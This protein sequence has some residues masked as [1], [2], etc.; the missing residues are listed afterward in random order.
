MYLKAYN[1][2]KIGHWMSQPIRL[3]IIKPQGVVIKE[4]NLGLDKRNSGS[5]PKFHSLPMP[6]HKAPYSLQSLFDLLVG[7]G[8]A[9]AD[10]IA[11]CAK[12]IAGNNGD[13]LF[14]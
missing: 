5:N 2:F 14:L 11:I 10:E 1:R 3:R 6:S 8:I 7:G 9:T 13:L 4:W 12:G